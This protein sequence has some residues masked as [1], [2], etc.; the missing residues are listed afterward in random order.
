M[1]AFEGC[2]LTIE[3]ED[4]QHSRYAL[5]LRP[6]TQDVD[7]TIEFFQGG[8]DQH[9]PIALA[10]IFSKY[11]REVLMEVFNAYWAGHVQ[12]LRRTAGYYEDG[13]RFLKDIEPAVQA[14]VDRP[15][16]AH[17]FTLTRHTIA[18]IDIQ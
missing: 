14:L 8:E 1:T 7:V 13:K 4:A 12:P 6:T 11:A 5:K 15:R 18:Q 3:C 9:L 17:S 10:S 16:Y 2:P